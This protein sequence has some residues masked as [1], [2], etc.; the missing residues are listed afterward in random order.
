MKAMRRLLAR[1]SLPPF[2]FGLLL[3]TLM[4]GHAA[5][6]WRIDIVS[7]LDAI[8]YDARLRLT[9]PEE[10][11]ERIVIV[12]IDE[13]SFTELGHWPW[14]RD[15][16]AG[17]VDELF[18]RQRIAVLGF[19]VV[20]AEADTSSGL[21]TLQALAE[22]PLRNEAGF[23]AQF[24]RLR[25]EL[26]RDARFAAALRGRPVILGY[27]F[28]S[29]EDAVSSGMLP[30]P[31]L[32]AGMFG[33]R[34]IAFTR[35]HS[36]GANLPILQQAAAGGGH[37]NSLVDFDGI[38]RRV[39]L[40]VEYQGAYQEA[41]SLAMLRAVL[42][43]PPI[44]PGYAEGRIAGYG[45]LEWL[46][47]P[48]EQGT[49]RLPVDE[50]VAALVPFRGRRGS[51][52]YV[53]AADVI[54]GRLPAGALAHRIVLVGTSAP[55]LMDLR[56]TPVD[57]AF[58]GVEIHANLIS[59]MLD[60]RLKDKPAWVL[61]ADAVQTLLVGLLLAVTL[62]LLSPLM[63]TLLWAG[64][65]LTLVAANFALWHAGNL[66]LPL[67][68]VLLL[69]TLLYVLDMSWGYF[70]EV[71]SKRQFASLFGQFVP[72]ELVEEMA[73]DP[74]HY[75]MEGR[76]ADLTV[77]FSDVRDFTAIAEG[78][79]PEALAALMNTYH[80][81]MTDV[82][83]RQRGTLDKYIGDAIMAFWGAPIADQ[84]HARQAVLAALEMQAALPEL[85]EQLAARGWPRLKIGIGV[86]T[87]PMTVG[88]MG[89]PVRKAY[90]VMGDAVNLGSRLEGLTKSYGVTI[91]I[92]ETTRAEAG[93]DIVY[94]EIDRVRVKGKD[95]AVAIYEP[96]G[97]A[98]VLGESRQSELR[99]WQTVLQA[100]RLQRWDEAEL[101]LYNLQRQWPH[102]LYELYA[103]RVATLKSQPPGANW[104]GCWK[105]VTK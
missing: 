5:H 4:F 92:G 10:K 40:L 35:W 60:G 81:T 99:L 53:S 69:A 48:T 1:R 27:Y 65:T 78:L 34:P 28:S 84:A 89:S 97:L 72:P 8:I 93:D 85:N 23:Q 18:V 6:W 58:P 52:P 7:R 31:V 64:V 15:V 22:G 80:G 46:E 103:E 102:K 61:G 47:L 62:P 26:D 82:I 68:G 11:D 73:R 105:F 66:V 104:D 24:A 25:D 79:A 63:A 90:T 32:P 17:M 20:F 67:A 50:N 33:D 95:Q 38:S 91:L 49:L 71:R 13:R 77:L 94:R 2:L 39:P 75:S 3:L 70:V 59:A 101:A 56:A 36:H 29:R 19:D 42:G 16:L 44:R 83:R 30:P 87:G 45:G 51:F 88:D 96:L 98:S 74:E 9:M 14:R 57:P 76:R 21:A 41:L 12:D 54:A 55:G 86:N 43:Q 100:Y 37:F